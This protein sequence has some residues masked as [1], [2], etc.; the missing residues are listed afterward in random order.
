MMRPAGDKNIEIR[1][2]FTR[3]RFKE[4]EQKFDLSFMK[5]H[6]TDENLFRSAVQMMDLKQLKYFGDS[7]Q[8]AD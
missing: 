7:T 2:R 1:Q 6:R 3:F 8:T 5:L 4:T